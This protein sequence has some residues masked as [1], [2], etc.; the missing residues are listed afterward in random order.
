MKSGRY[1]PLTMIFDGYG[2]DPIITYYRL[3]Q[4]YHDIFDGFMQISTSGERPY[5]VESENMNDIK[6]LIEEEQS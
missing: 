1:V 4:K 6:K 2:N 5:I 3:K